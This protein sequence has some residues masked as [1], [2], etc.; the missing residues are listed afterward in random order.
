MS[1]TDKDSGYKAFLRMLTSGPKSVDIGILSDEPKER[2]TDDG[3]PGGRTL[4]D[5]ALANEYGEEG[6]PKR[7]FIRGWVDENKPGIIST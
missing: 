2:S 4:I 3:A 7:S 6:T 1:I 5:V